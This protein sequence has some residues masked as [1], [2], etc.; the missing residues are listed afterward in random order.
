MK[1]LTIV[2]GTTSTQKISYLKEVMKELQIKAVVKPIEVKSEISDQPTTS[3]ETKTGSINRAKNALKEIKNTDF[4]LGIEVGYHK[5]S[6][7]KYEMFCW[8]TIIDK[9]GHKNI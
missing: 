5:Y 7:N 2:V 6:K 1:K 9:Q 4:S 8:V 3:K